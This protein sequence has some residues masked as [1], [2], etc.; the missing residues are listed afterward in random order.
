MCMAGLAF[1]GRAEQGCHFGLAFHVGL[2]CEVQV[3]AV[4]LAFAG[5][6]GFQVVVRFGAFKGG[7]RILRLLRASSV[8]GYGLS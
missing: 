8:D 7:H 1:S 5:E 2:V 3:T 6:S 4:G